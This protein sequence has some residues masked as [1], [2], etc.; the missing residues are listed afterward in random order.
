MHVIRCQ[1]RHVY[2]R[3][4]TTCSKY[5]N[6]SR[7]NNQ[8]KWVI[9]IFNFVMNKIFIWVQLV[10][11]R[12]ATA[13]TWLSNHLTVK[14]S[15]S[16]IPE[17]HLKS[18]M[19]TEALLQWPNLEPFVQN[20]QRKGQSLLQLWYSLFLGAFEYLVVKRCLFATWVPDMFQEV[21]SLRIFN[22]G[23]SAALDSSWRV[24]FKYCLKEKEISFL[25]E[26]I[27]V[28]EVHNPNHQ[29]V[30]SDSTLGQWSTKTSDEKCANET[31][32]HTRNQVPQIVLKTNFHKVKYL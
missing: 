2:K 16:P 8:H 25:K 7:L 10:T 21:H 3:D 23:R 18:P 30:V 19:V 20:P 12:A 31:R 15:S 13:L 26:W 24:L 27:A 5:N 9:K 29:R 22:E 28:H 32:P 11:R 4:W 17:H 14:L 1:I 6:H